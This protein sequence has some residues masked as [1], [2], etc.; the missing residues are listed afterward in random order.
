MPPCGLQAVPR[1]LLDHLCDLGEARNWGQS[2]RHGHDGYFGNLFRGEL[3]L[4]LGLVEA[5]E[6]DERYES[7]AVV[8]VPSNLIQGLGF[9]V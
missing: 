8:P 2:T 4:S 6:L 9:R 1:L 7:L 5:D 3:A